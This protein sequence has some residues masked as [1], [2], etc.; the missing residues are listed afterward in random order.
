MEKEKNK[1]LK[2]IDNGIHF[3]GIAKENNKVIFVPGAVEGEEVRAKIVKKSSSYDVAE[4]TEITKASKH[5]QMKTECEVQGSCG[6]CVGMHMKYDYTLKIKKDTVINTLKKQGINNVVRD[7]YGMGMPYNYR[8]KIQYPVRLIN[9]K[10]KMGMFIAKTHNVIETSECKIQEKEINEI[11]RLMFDLMCEEGLKG[12]DEKTKKGHIKNIIV[13]KGINTGDILCIYVVNDRKIIG[14]KEMKNIVEEIAK[15]YPNVKGIIANINDKNTNVIL[16]KENRVLYGKDKIIDIIGDK[17]YYISTNS[18]FQVNTIAAEVL[19]NVLKQNLRL[20]K[21]QKL[22]EL[23]SGVGTIGIFLSDSVKEV[24]GVEIVE[25]AVKMAE[26]NVKLNDINNTK[27]ILGDAKEELYKL[28][29][30]GNQ[31][32]VLVVDPPRRGLEE[33][34]IKLIKEMKTKKI[35]YIS[36]NP[37]T[38]ARDLAHLK[39]D[40]DIISVDIVDMFPWTYHVECAVL[41]S[42]VDK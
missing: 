29:K 24:I 36:C 28:K 40:Y 8:N 21:N 11:A 3:E 17:S 14:S 2:I 23:Y 12:Y 5:R 31:Y 13:R 27:Y 39:D 18:F 19:Y 16:A 9:G 22:I 15:K 37:A 38:L 42:R 4:I 41:M 34:G 30:Q 6:G 33:Q 35:G 25:D 7:I 32:D 10:N 20:E 1:M 26:E